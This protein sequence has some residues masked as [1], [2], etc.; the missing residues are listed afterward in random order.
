MPMFVNTEN[1][2]A[3]F[4]FNQPIFCGHAG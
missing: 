2:F 4:G 1:P 3:F